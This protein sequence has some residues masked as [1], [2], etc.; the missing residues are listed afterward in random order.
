M[1]NKKKRK[2][3]RANQDTNKYLRFAIIPLLI[4]I[5][6]IFVLLFDRKE[7]EIS[8]I[9]VATSSEAVNLTLETENIEPDNNQYEIDFSAFEL[10]RDQGT[11]LTELVEKYCQAHM[12]SDVDL[13]AE[14]YNMTMSEDQ[15]E[16]RAAQ[17]DLVCKFV[18]SYENIGCY[19]VDGPEPDTYVIFPYY[20]VKFKGAELAVPNL[21]II[22]ALKDEQGNLYMTDRYMSDEHL[23]DYVT[24]VKTME[25]VILLSK[26][27]KEQEQEAINQDEVLQAIYSVLTAPPE[28]GDAEVIISDTQPGDEAE[29]GET[30]VDEDEGAGLIEPEDNSLAETTETTTE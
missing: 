11:E 18:E 12:E 15:K 21:S 17:M 9:P 6:V 14:V 22:Y 3:G 27:I 1:E 23:S 4:I 10:H 28:S 24:K 30:C 7:T 19:Y 8:T 20:E 16:E 25:D 13:L 26:Q 29:T 5:I 2:R